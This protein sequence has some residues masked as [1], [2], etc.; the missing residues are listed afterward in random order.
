MLRLHFGCGEM[1]AGDSPGSELLRE[2][3][4]NEGETVVFLALVGAK[5]GPAQSRFQNLEFVKVH[6]QI[7]RV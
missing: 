6:I 3:C 7:V 5:G 2:E 1:W 4:D